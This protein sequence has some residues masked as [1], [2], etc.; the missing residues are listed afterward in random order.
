MTEADCVELLRWAAPRLGLRWAGFRNVRRIACKQLARRA[1]ALGLADAAAYR[2][3]LERDPDEWILLDSYCRIPISRFFRDRAV[4]ERLGAELLPSLAAARRGAPLAAWSAGCASGEE[5][6]TLA[7]VWHAQLAARFPEVALDLLGTDAAPERIARA[8][9]GLYPPGCLRELPAPLREAAFEPAPDGE[10][11]LR[12]AFRR[13]VR[14]AVG[15]LRAHL[16]DG[17]F[18]L[19]LCRNVAFTY[20]DEAHQRETLARLADRLRPGGVLVIGAHEALPDGADA[21]LAPLGP[22]LFRRA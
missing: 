16:P 22:S 5:P 19:V 3:L 21:R 4:W 14:F 6:Y 1:R 10:M 9:R 15:D 13:G 17:P 20:F 18:D 2:A 11:R 12:D 8:E 7:L